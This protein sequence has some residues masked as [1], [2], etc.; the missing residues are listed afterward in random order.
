MLRRRI[1]SALAR[2]LLWLGALAVAALLLSVAGY[3]CVRGLPGL[4][5]QFLTGQESALRGTEGI[6]PAVVNTLFVIMVSL[7]VVLPVGVGAAVY[8][9]EYA[10]SRRLVGVIDFAAGVLSG[11][12]SILYAMLGVLLFCDRLGLRRTLL[13]GSMTLAIMTLPT[14]LRTTRESLR[15]APASY[16]EGALGLGAG[17]WSMIRSVVLP[18]SVDGVVTGCILAAGRVVGETA[19]LL[20][21]A[22]LSTAMQDFSGLRAAARASGA[23][24]ST[25]LYV[26]AKERADFTAAFAVATVLL[27]VAALLNAAAAAAGRRL[28]R[29]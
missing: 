2:G 17:K 9:T 8:L 16:R 28:R 21:T 15:A 25:V 27:A 20:Y 18:A 19:V 13:A 26:Y 22:G 23:T 1:C 14:V 5:W 7:A 12:P 24:L 29:V 4:S 6:L 3:V 11:I 10:G